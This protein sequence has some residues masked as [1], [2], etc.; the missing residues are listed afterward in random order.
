MVS[1]AD[2]LNEFLAWCL[3]IQSYLGARNQ[4]NPYTITDTPFSNSFGLGAT[5]RDRVQAVFDANFATL[6]VGNGS[7]AAAFQVA[8]WNAVYD[9]DWTATGGLFSVSAG[10]FIEGLADGFL[11]QAQAYAGGKQ[12]NLTFWESTPGQQQTKRQNLVSV[13]PVPL[14]AAGVLMIGALGGLVALR[15]R[16]RPA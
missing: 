7:Q 8:L 4:A 3:D 5:G 10:N 14:P 12:Y 13:A 2:P 1:S 11:A 6:D 9:D 16:K 15:R